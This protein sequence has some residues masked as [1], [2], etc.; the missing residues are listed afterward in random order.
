MLALFAILLHVWKGEP[1]HHTTP[2][3][4]QCSDMEILN[5]LI[6]VLVAQT[7]YPALVLWCPLIGYCFAITKLVDRLSRLQQHWY[8]LVY[9]SVNISVNFHWYFHCQWWNVTTKFYDWHCTFDTDFLTVWI[10]VPSSFSRLTWLILSSCFRFLL[11][12]GRG[13]NSQQWTLLI[14]GKYTLLIL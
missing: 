11:V 13:P 12:R 10:L 2:P 14:I 1:T 5:I 9:I 7:I 6:G 3:W 4:W 8:K